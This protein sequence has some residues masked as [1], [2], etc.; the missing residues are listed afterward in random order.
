MQ[1]WQYGY[2]YD[3]E[4]FVRTGEPSAR[5][6]IVVDARGTWLLGQTRQLA[7]LNDLGAEGWIISQNERANAKSLQDGSWI[8]DFMRKSIP[9]FA[10]INLIGQYFMRGPIDR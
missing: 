7:A 1:K 5:H 10:H 4:V 6:F 3:V 9:T 8:V 2:L